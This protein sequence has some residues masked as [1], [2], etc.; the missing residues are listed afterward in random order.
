MGGMASRP[1][2]FPGE[3]SRVDDSLAQMDM[4]VHK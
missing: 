1:R 4:T 2:G 3:Y